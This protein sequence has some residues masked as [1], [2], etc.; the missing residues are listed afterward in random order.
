MTSFLA[1]HYGI[2]DGL[3]GRHEMV[4]ILCLDPLFANVV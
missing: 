4:A 3:H 2:A 1:S